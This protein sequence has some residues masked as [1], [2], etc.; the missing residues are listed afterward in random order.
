MIVVPFIELKSEI[1]RERKLENVGSTQMP[2][3]E[4]MH[5]IRISVEAEFSLRHKIIPRSSA[6]ASHRWAE[7]E[8]EREREGKSSSTMH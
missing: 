3:S 4:K 1:E 7:R 8:K 5:F 6:H 2:M